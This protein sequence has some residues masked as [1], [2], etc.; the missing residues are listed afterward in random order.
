MNHDVDVENKI[1][2]IGMKT[3]RH[4][5]QITANIK[6]VAVPHFTETCAVN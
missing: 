2:E 6:S 1:F 4:N 3:S 5:V